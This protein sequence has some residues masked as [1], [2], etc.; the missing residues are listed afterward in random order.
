MLETLESKKPTAV[1]V[2]DRV[3]KD[4]KDLQALNEEGLFG[5]LGAIVTGIPEEK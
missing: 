2:I 1:V 4:V 5:I 3:N